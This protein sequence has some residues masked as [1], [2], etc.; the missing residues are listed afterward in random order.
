MTEGSRCGPL[1]LAENNEYLAGVRSHALICSQ[2]GPEEES[3]SA[4]SGVS[5]SRKVLWPFNPS[6][7]YRGLIDLH[8]P[9][10]ASVVIRKC[11]LC[12]VR[13]MRPR[14]L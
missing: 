5:I 10:S 1:K 3:E 4:W 14:S 7:R 11:L 13:C 8:I 9:D 2:S 12:A 6:L